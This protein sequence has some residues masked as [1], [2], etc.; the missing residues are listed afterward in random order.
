VPSL[1]PDP[2]AK[3]SRP[4]PTPLV[5]APPVVRE[6][7]TRRAAARGPGDVATG[8]QPCRRTRGRATTRLEPRAESGCA[9]GCA[10]AASNGS[11]RAAD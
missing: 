2:V 3:C 4:A 11:N 1:A 10:C 5:Q 6:L 7:D 8:T 9:S